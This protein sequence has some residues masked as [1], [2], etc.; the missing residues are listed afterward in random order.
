VFCDYLRAD[1]WA[2]RAVRDGRYKYVQFLDAPELLFALE[3][4][5]LERTNLAPDADGETEDVL[6]RLR[7][8]VDR[9]FD[10][11]AA[12]ERRRRNHRRRAD[13]HSLDVPERPL[14]ESGNL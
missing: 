5:P 1:Q 13:K 2:F 7:S 8:L 12:A 14:G 11:E 10:F 6:D 3:A 4:D 9:T